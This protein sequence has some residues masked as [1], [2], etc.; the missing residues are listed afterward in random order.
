MRSKWHTLAVAGT[1]GIF[2]SWNAATADDNSSDAWPPR[3]DHKAAANAAGTNSEVRGHVQELLRQAMAEMD[4]NRFESARRLTRRA[5]AIGV[6]AGFVGVHPEQLLA[7]IDRREHDAADA[8]RMVPGNP[9]RSYKARAIELL[10]RGL[11]AL[12]E[13][14]FDDAE[15]FARQAAQLHVTWDKYDYR[16]ENLLD[17]IR[18]QSPSIAQERE[19]KPAADSAFDA[20][21]SRAAE[22]NPPI[23]RVDR[24]SGSVPS[25]PTVASRATDP[26]PV[27]PV[28]AAGVRHS[29]AETLLEQAMDDLRAGRD[30]LARQRLEQALGA[31]PGSPRN[32]AVASFGD[33]AASNS[34]RPIGL[35]PS[36]LM[37]G[38]AGSSSSTAAQ[39]F[40]PIRRDQPNV[41]SAPH[42]GAD[43]VLKP[44][45]DPYLGDEPT[46]T[47]K[48][49]PGAQTMRESIPLAAP[50][51]PVYVNGSGTP[52]MAETNL[53]KV[54][55][56]A[57]ATPAT[58]FSPLPPRVQTA[59][60]APAIT[61]QI[62][63]LEKMSVPIPP[64]GAPGGRP[65][66]APAASPGF[67]PAPIAPAVPMDSQ[68]SNGRMSTPSGTDPAIAN[69]PDQPKPSFFH[70]I[71]DAISGE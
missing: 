5:A 13:K 61:P 41:V 34:N 18:R 17:E 9:G 24:T 46:T 55:Y 40:F 10:D 45:H 69:S 56:D 43:V 32:A 15:R 60:N 57:P 66:N 70:K 48:S 71:W 14:R 29:P 23:D 42:P 39:V 30:E 12:D 4:A 50:I 54:A 38:Y 52:S 20:R 8:S 59:P 7:E 64:Q 16:P 51:N 27:P 49:S 3:A 28:D 65:S 2:M 25:L 31:L 22:V 35:P 11:L 62:G 63:W 6:S 33:S 53:Q 26:S 1:L 44:M 19:T 68:S 36:G 58:P 67:N 37:P 21:L 47:D